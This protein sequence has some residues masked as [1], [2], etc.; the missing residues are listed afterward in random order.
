MVVL[1]NGPLMYVYKPSD[2]AMDSKKQSWDG[3]PMRFAERHCVGEPQS[4]VQKHKCRYD[5]LMLIHVC[6]KSIH[7]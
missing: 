3:H 6:M 7:A 4:Q 5:I 1:C 2:Q